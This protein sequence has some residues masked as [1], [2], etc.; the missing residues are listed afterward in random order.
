MLVSKIYS[1]LGLCVCQTE[2]IT[3]LPKC[4]AV[5][6]SLKWHRIL[7]GDICQIH[8]IF[9]I[10]GCKYT[11]VCIPK[12]NL[13]MNSFCI[14]QFNYCPYLWIYHSRLVNNKI[15]R[16]QKKSSSFEELVDTEWSVTIRKRNLKVLA[17]YCSW[18][19]SHLPE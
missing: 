3:E 12:R 15:T 13:Q 5:S 16:L 10:C 8:D 11:S 4:M 2:T 7:N 17:K 6:A 1:T 14:L 19:F 9:A 18:N